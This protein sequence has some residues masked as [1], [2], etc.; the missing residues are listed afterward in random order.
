RL[1]AFAFAGLVALV[2]FGYLTR[3]RWSVARIATVLLTLT[4]YAG[5]IFGPTPLYSFTGATLFAICFLYGAALSERKIDWEPVALWYL[6]LNMIVSI[7]AYMLELPFAQTINYPDGQHP[8]VRMAGLNSHA[9]IH[10][11]FATTGLVLAG[12]MWR[13]RRLALWAFG[14]TAVLWFVCIDLADARAYLI[15]GV[16]SLVYIMSSRR[17]QVV[18]A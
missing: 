6:V 1:A 8:I 4:F 5:A 7:I 18:T 9:L 15:F 3:M 17:I 16:T 10:A 12:S 13:R 11:T 2:N 14:I